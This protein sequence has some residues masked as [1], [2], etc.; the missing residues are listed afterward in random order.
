MAGKVYIFNLFNEPAELSFNGAPAGTGTIA[1]WDKTKGYTPGYIAVD[2][3]K[4]ND[5]DSGKVFR[6]GN[7]SNDV[8][9][10]WDS[11]VAIGKIIFPTV[12]DD[13]SIDDDLV[14]Y[15]A[16]NSAFVETTDGFVSKEGQQTLT[17]TQTS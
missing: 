16:K 5:E 17:F 11:G 15:I 1:G 2:S 4:H 6:G 10:E 9:I 3:A 14:C 12:S 7:G 13:V 8:R